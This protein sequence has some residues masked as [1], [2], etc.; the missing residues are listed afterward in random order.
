MYI[1]FRF[2]FSIFMTMLMAFS[3][4]ASLSLPDFD[5]LMLNW[6]SHESQT[7]VDSLT[8][9][10]ASGKVGDGNNCE[11]SGG[12]D[13]AAWLSLF[14]PRSLSGIMPAIS[15]PRTANSN[16][17]FTA[18]ANVECCEFSFNLRN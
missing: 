13:G 12:N 6:Q 9:L 8:Q 18:N 7:T 11:F 16:S 2:D 15:R 14:L 3:C 4:L 1:V 17:N 10:V 5:G